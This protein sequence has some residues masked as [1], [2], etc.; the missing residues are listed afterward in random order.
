MFLSH[1]TDRIMDTGHLLLQSR[2]ELL[3][4]CCLG[5]DGEVVPSHEL[6][7]PVS[8]SLKLW[9]DRLYRQHC[10]VYDVFNTNS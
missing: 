7:S 10:L 2:G 5:S 9:A 6:L 1:F 8:V 4:D 3:S